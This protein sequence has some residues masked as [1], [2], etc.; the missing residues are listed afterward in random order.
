MTAGAAEM[1]DGLD[2]TTAGAFATTTGVTETIGGTAASAVS[3]VDGGFGVATAGVTGRWRGGRVLV[4]LRAVR[5]H[6]RRRCDR[7]T[8]RSLACGQFPERLSVD[9]SGRQPQSG[10][11]RRQAEAALPA[12]ISGHSTT[13]AR[14]RV[15]YSFLSAKIGTPRTTS[16][17]RWVPM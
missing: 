2:E 8:P 17:S 11:E 14:L 5:V 16:I 6:T 9:V 15:H 7:R 12:A 1:T 13:V 3:V 4:R 10:D